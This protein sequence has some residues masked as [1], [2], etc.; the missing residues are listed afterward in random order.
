[1]SR[2]PG[3]K[4]TGMVSNG[5][6]CSKNAVRCSLF[7]S[8]LGL[9]C[10]QPPVVFAVVF[11]CCSVRMLFCSTVRS[12]CV[13]CFVRMPIVVFAVLFALYRFLVLWASLVQ[14]S[15]VERSLFCSMFCSR[16]KVNV[17][18]DVR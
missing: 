9:L 17:L 16:Q 3:N 4:Q 14:M 13:R 1:M 8:T 5:V 2:I 18:F 11:T 6:R 7:C 10:S 12:C 15:L